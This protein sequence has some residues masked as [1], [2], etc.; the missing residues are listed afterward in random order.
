MVRPVSIVAAVA[1]A[2]LALVVAQSAPTCVVNCVGT[3]A[4]ATSCA[5]SD[6]QCL[7]VSSAFL[8]SVASCYAS[9]CDSEDAAVGVIFGEQ[10]CASIGITVS[11]PDAYASSIASL[12]ASA[13]DA[14]ASA[15]ALQV[16]A[17]AAGATLT[18]TTSSAPSSTSAAPS[19][20]ATVISSSA[21][22]AA[23]SSTPAS[24]ASTLVG[25]A[26]LAFVGV[27][28]AALVQ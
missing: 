18:S 7:C 22:A 1:F 3:A 28:V 4:A 17:E 11:I 10:Y 23:A 6:V 2:P 5:T 9:D 21:S 8:E 12:T 27:G 24:G 16:S 20:T 25:S 15:S 13:T 14:A 26:L 19:S